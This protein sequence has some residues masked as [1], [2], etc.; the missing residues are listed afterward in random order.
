MQLI[1]I[2]SN[3]FTK[4]RIAFLAKIVKILY[5]LFPASFIKYLK[6]WVPLILLILSYIRIFNFILGIIFFI[7]LMDHFSIDELIRTFKRAKDFIICEFLAVI[8]KIFNTGYSG[9]RP[10]VVIE[11]DNADRGD[12][13]SAPSV[14]EKIESDAREFQAQSPNEYNGFSFFSYL[15]IML[16]LAILSLFGI[17]VYNNYD[18][19]RETINEFKDKIDRKNNGGDPSSGGSSS[20]PLGRNT[21]K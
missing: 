12:M 19:I 7:A 8:D 4:T 15:K 3:I 18:E 11:I 2:L 13:F 10:K 21:I 16:G 1:K 6:L 9:G 20:G 5:T 14:L 17:F